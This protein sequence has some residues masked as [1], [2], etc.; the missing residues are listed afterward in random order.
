MIKANF[1]FYGLESELH[2]FLES[3]KYNFIFEKILEF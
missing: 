3:K 2:N 1:Y